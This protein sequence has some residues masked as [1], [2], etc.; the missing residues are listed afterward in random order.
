VTRQKDR[1]KDPLRVYIKWALLSWPYNA[2]LVN[3]ASRISTF[4]GA[5]RI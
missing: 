1:G 3:V 4:I 5:Q 2:Q